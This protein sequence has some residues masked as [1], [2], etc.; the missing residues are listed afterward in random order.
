MP[1]FV[2]EIHDGLLSCGST[3]APGADGFNI[4]FYKRAWRIMQDDIV[5]LFRTLYIS[6]KIPK[7]LN[8]SFLILIPKVVG[9]CYLLEFRSISLINGVFKL[10]SKVLSFR[11]RSVLSFVISENQHAFIKGRSTLDCSMVASEIVHTLARR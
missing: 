8:S 7:G 3:K 11:L 5:A 4:L 10:I 9:I 2:T 1:F 6:G